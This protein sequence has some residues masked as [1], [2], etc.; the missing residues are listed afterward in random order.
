[1]SIAR[2]E[3]PPLPKEPGLYTRIVAKTLYHGT[4][5]STWTLVA[6]WTPLLKDSAVDLEKEAGKLD[7]AT[8][9]LESIKFQNAQPEDKGCDAEYVILPVD[10]LRTSVIK[11]QQVKIKRR[12]TYD[13]SH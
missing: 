4:W 3:E 12:V 9:L 5:Y 1:M 13:V 2:N 10:V 7:N 8:A 11:V 6:E